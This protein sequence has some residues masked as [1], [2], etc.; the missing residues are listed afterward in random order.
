M[1]NRECIERITKMVEELR[2][3]DVTKEE[4][5]EALKDATFNEISDEIWNYYCFVCDVKRALMEVKE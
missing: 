2:L 3:A 1:S 4:A 5:I